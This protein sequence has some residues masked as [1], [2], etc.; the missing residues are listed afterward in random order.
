MNDEEW[1]RAAYDE[2]G[3]NKLDLVLATLLWNI[4]RVFRTRLN[5]NGRCGERGS[6]TQKSDS[7]L[8]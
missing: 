4:P 6:M 7:L 2:R 3:S 8:A 1:E 5:G